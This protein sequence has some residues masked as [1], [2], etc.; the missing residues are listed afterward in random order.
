MGAKEAFSASAAE[1]VDADEV[2]IDPLTIL[3]II[4]TILPTLLSCFTAHDSDDPTDIK[5]AVEAEYQH[6]GTRLRNRIAHRIRMETSSPKLRSAQAKAIADGIVAEL[7]ETPT[8]T[9]VRGCQ[10]MGAV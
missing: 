3:T 6:R 5:S 1:R 4:T 8:A 7:K 2:G 10:E 9:I